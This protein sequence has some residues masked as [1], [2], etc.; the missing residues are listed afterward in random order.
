MTIV[1]TSILFLLYF[2]HP[3]ISGHM[4]LKLVYLTNHKVKLTAFA[5]LGMEDIELL[6][7]S[8]LGLAFIHR[9]WFNWQN[10]SVSSYSTLYGQ[11]STQ[12]FHFPNRNAPK[13]ALFIQMPPLTLPLTRCSCLWKRTPKHT[14]NFHLNDIRVTNSNKELLLFK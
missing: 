9:I 5:Q 10:H 14:M 7:C 8:A 11:K 6:A 1:S 2:Y 12:I 4:S 13:L 3:G